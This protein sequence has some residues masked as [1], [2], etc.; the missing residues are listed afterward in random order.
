[1]RRNIATI[2][3]ALLATTPA[4]AVAATTCNGHP[5]LCTRRYTDV[6]FFGAHGS[7]FVG[8]SVS[9][10][11]NIPIPDQLAMG[12]RFLQAQTHTKNNGKIQLCHTDCNLED[13]GTLR[14]ALLAPV[15]TFLDENPAEVVTLLLTNPDGFRDKDFAKVFR[16]SGLRKYAFAGVQTNVSLHEWPTLGEMIESGK[17]LV[18]F[19]G[20]Y[21]R[22]DGI[23]R[24]LLSAK[25][26][27]VV[28][29][30]CLG[31]IFRLPQGSLCPVHTG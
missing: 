5:E 27:C 3:K 11:Q 20:S 4:V 15:K 25:N 22:T 31:C 19:V 16:Q 24:I 9:S 1:M 26:R 13:A 12:V 10:N 17:R 23:H 30:D 28:T 29:A 6:T 14:E 21:S 8:T 7:P 2:I 18:V